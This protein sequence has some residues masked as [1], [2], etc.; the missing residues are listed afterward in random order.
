MI[1]INT[2]LFL[3]DV[4]A[5]A[6]SEQY[7]PDGTEILTTVNVAVEKSI[8]AQHEV[9]T[10]FAIEGLVHTGNFY[11]ADPL[12]VL[13][14]VCDK[15]ENFFP[16]VPAKVKKLYTAYRESLGG[17]FSPVTTEPKKPKAPKTT[18]RR[19]PTLMEKLMKDDNMKP[20]TI[21]EDGFYVSPTKWY[22][23][24]RNVMRRK[25]TLITG[26]TGTG[27]TTL[28]EI[29]ARKLNRTLH[30]FDMGSIAD[31]Q[32]AL[33]GTHRIINGES[34]FDYAKFVHVVQEENPMILIDEITRTGPNV[35]NIFFPVLDHRRYVPIEIADS[36]HDRTIKVSENA[37][38]VATANIGAEYQGT[39][40]LDRALLRR[41]IPVEM[42]YMT[43]DQEIR[44]LMQ[45]TK[46][47]EKAAK[48]L[49]RFADDVRVQARDGKLT[50][51]L[52]HG[53][54]LEL[55]EMIKDGVS[56]VDAAK[57]SILPL[58]EGTEKEGDKCT[59]L[60]IIAK[61]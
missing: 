49:A 29:M 43:V 19:I 51:S 13:I 35:N 22:F 34:V 33:L 46:I 31:P 23:I 6:L 45:R 28:M 53:E 30:A 59:I 50:T 39:Y 1:F 56:F 52:S 40:Q 18:P 27:K 61:Y 58:F 4:K 60:G 26:P 38:F 47:E 7:F 57:E 48:Q 12:E 17:G 37:V 32:A 15:N 44:V 54:I 3:T 21:E 41:F 11:R 42:D 16:N 10:V 9:G 8:R 5:R 36:Q 20:P 14:P 2:S 25:N 24:L 55:G